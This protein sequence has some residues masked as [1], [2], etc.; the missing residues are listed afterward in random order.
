MIPSQLCC[1]FT[2]IDCTIIHYV[3]SRAGCAATVIVCLPTRGLKSAK[4]DK[5][6]GRTVHSQISHEVTQ[7]LDIKSQWGGCG[8]AG[9]GGA[10]KQ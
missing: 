10:V 9:R 2:T 4:P 6:A 8:S 1:I 3:L 7:L 5:S